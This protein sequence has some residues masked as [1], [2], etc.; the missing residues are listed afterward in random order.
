MRLRWLLV[1]SLAVVANQACRQASQP[2]A[3]PGSHTENAAGTRK[4]KDAVT[5]PQAEHVEPPSTL[6]KAQQAEASPSTTPPATSLPTTP[7]TSADPDRYLV[8]WW[9]GLELPSLADAPARYSR[10][11]PDSFGELELAGERAR[12]ASCVEWSEL[13]SKGFGPINTVEGQADDGAKIRCGTLKL[14]QSAKPATQSY[15]RDVPWNRKLLSLLPAAVAT[16]LS[17]D[18]ER[19]VHAATTGGKTFAQFDSKARPKPGSEAATLEIIE[20]DRQT[21]IVIH[22]EAWGDFNDDGTD[23]VL[24][25]VVN[26]ATQGTLAYVRL[27]TLTRF[28]QTESLSA[29][30]SEN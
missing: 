10:L 5:S 19:A 17:Q 11:E 21:M 9:D 16:S 4:Y 24:V 26:G 25:S 8:K 6:H 14:L 22:A 23:D 3:Q 30:G 29:I 7:P 13:H 12:P 15:V 28:S 18:D 27:M 20:G 2:S 1:V